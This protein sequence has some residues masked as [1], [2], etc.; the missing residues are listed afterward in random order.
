M[1]ARHETRLSGNLCAATTGSAGHISRAQIQ[2]SCPTT[3]PRTEP[4]T[5]MN[6][7]E[8]IRGGIKWVLA[9]RVGRQ[10]LHLAF[11]I[12]LARL[13]MPE[14]F[15]LLITVQIFTGAAMLVAGGGMGQAL[16]QTKTLGPHDSHVIFTAQL[17]LGVLLYALFFSIA[18][19]FAQWFN[20]PIYT[21]LLRVSAITFL[22]RPLSDVPSSLLQRAMRYKAH[23]IIHALAGVVGGAAS[24]SMA[25]AG[26]GVWSLVLGGLVGTVASIALLLAA[27]R[28]TPR[29]KMDRTI[30]ERLGTYGVKV[31]GNN[32]VS[33][34]FS[35]TPNFVLSRFVGPAEVGLFNKAVSLSAAPNEI[36]GRSTKKV[37]FRALSETQEN[38]DQSRYVLFRS[39][40]LITVY[41]FPFFVGFWWVA[42]SLIITVYGSHWA[43]AAPP[44]QILALGGFFAILTTQF[45]AVTA[46]RNLLGAEMFIRIASWA[47]LI[48]LL[49]PTYTHGI[50]AVAWAL[51]AT[52]ILRSIL[53]YTLVA[54]NLGF[55]IQTFAKA[56]KPAIVLNTILLVTLWSTHALLVA[57]Y[58]D[59]YPLYL[60]AMTTT[61]T[62]T[63]AISFLYL[64][65]RDLSNE[66]ARW[67]RVLR[68]TRKRPRPT[69]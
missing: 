2:P 19:W 44:L 47:V 28:W 18:P 27:T 35:Q 63:Y 24:I 25:V 54:G 32:I 29:I 31:S 23:A 37:I 45:S 50:S 12:A 38:L 21:D 64:P 43:E 20:E 39:T 53:L 62:L 55:T 49:I 15:G 8:R 9:G 3:Q 68:L 5:S 14:D 7:G 40:L 61:G 69:P 16:V 56:L 22:V 30:L 57:P 10:I 67:K 59:Q 42:E 11:A 65:L 4:R 13:L 52:T 1:S 66:Q 46:A 51:V 48:V 58:Q 6:L 60:L 36:L 26:W 17:V 41:T 33:H 34:F